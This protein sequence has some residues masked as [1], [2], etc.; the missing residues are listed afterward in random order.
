MRHGQI[1]SITLSDE[2][3]WGARRGASPL[4]ATPAPYGLICVPT[5][6]HQHGC[7]CPTRPGGRASTYSA[8]LPTSAPWITPAGEA[9]RTDR[10]SCPCQ[11]PVRMPS[12]LYLMVSGD[13]THSQHTF[14]Y[15]PGARSILHGKEDMTGIRGVSHEHSRRSIG[16]RGIRASFSAL[17]LARPRRCRQL[18]QLLRMGR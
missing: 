6:R 18:G 15:L 4:D 8:D 12:R 16:L 1:D 17:A 7:L 10:R 9:S 13:Q 2:K 11:R 14:S 3:D 5:L